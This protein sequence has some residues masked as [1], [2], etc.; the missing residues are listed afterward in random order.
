[1][2]S[3]KEERALIQSIKKSTT[4]LM[5]R[6]TLPPSFGGMIKIVWDIYYA[7]DQDAKDARFTAHEDGV[8]T[9]VWGQQFKS[10]LL[11]SRT[12]GAILACWPKILKT[13]RQVSR[14]KRIGA[15]NLGLVIA[16]DW[17]QVGGPKGI[18]RCTECLTFALST[19]GKEKRD[20]ETCKPESA[21]ML[22]G[23]ASGTGH[24][25]IALSHQGSP[26]LFCFKCGCRS[27]NKARELRRPCKGRPS[28]TRRWVLANLMNGIHP[29][30]KE[31]LH[32]APYI[33]DA[34]ER[35]SA[36][37]GYGLTTRHWGQTDRDVAI[38]ID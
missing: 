14:P 27:E 37:Y 11:L 16:H 19:A 34:M 25:L 18:W 32:D 12:I 22:V 20:W 24:Q 8:C 33:E 36:A 10:A 7:V 38:D 31:P 9:D 26:L 17:I 23:I 4:V 5:A 29:V 21:K 30:T 35:W 2:P 28:G 1:M 13:G 15:A 6:S 3:L